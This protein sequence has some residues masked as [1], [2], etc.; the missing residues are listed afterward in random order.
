MELPRR[1]RY[2]HFPS[3]DA[4]GIFNA[5]LAILD[6][7]DAM[8][9]YSV[10]FAATPRRKMP[11]LWVGVVGNTGIWPLAFQTLP[12]QA[13]TNLMAVEADDS[14]PM[15]DIASEQKIYSPAVEGFFFALSL[16]CLV[17]CYLLLKTQY[18]T[19]EQ[20]PERP[21]TNMLMGDA[22]LDEFRRERWMRISAFIGAFLMTYFV[23]VA[24]LMLPLRG[25]F[26]IAV[27]G[28]PFAD[29]FAAA[30]SMSFPAILACVLGVVVLL[31]LLAAQSI[32]LARIRT[33]TTILPN[34]TSG[35]SSRLYGRDL[36]PH[37]H[38]YRPY[39]GRG[40]RR[41]GMVLAGAFCSAAN[42][43]RA[44]NLGSSVSPLKPLLFL[45]IANI[46]LIACDIWQFT[47]LEDCRIELPFLG[48]EQGGES[49][50]GTNAYEQEVVKLLESPPW[51]LP[52]VHF[53]LAFSLIGLIAFA[54]SS[55]WP[56]IHSIDGAAF[57]VLFALSSIYIYTYFSILLLRFVLDGARCINCCAASTGIR[58]GLATKRCASN[59]SP[60]V[61]RTSA[62][63]LW[64]LPRASPRSSSAWT[65]PAR[66]CG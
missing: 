6:R 19:V 50:Q 10:P 40:L 11:P 5:T 24:F 44:A 14:D 63:G 13:L 20:K 56:P 8:V 28:A 61:P 25:A 46:C 58:P 15:Q 45:T 38:R 51:A 64:N 35:V 4:E 54:L 59:R 55:G 9:D 41:R 62:S 48:F 22:V 23:A 1:G 57:D 37:R 53:F 31:A 32:A 17:P 29:L 65:A 42:F 30:G 34:S 2:I 12:P 39:P 52:G 7:R 27:T 36:L 3:E 66:C 16:L 21:W 33:S 43:M 47:F 49:F 18:A 60:N 26:G